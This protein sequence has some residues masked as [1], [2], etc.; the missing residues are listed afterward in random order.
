MANAQTTQTNCTVSG[1]LYGIRKLRVA[2]RKKKNSVQPA[3]SHLVSRLAFMLVIAAEAIMSLAATV[4]NVL[5]K[6]ILSPTDRF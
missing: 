5:A 6:K 2:T 1:I 4:L 3:I